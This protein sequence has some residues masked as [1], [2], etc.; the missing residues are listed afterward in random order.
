MPRVFLGYIGIFTQIISPAK[1]F[2]SAFYTVQRGTAASVRIEEIID[3]EETIAEPVN[4]K[5]LSAFNSEIRFN[6]VS[7]G[8][9]S[10]PV[11]QNI[12]LTIKKGQT[13]ALV[14][15]SGGGKSTLADLLP[16]FYD[17]TSG[18]ITIDGIDIRDLPL[19]ELRSLMGIVSQ[20]SIL[21]NDTLYNNIA[22]GKTGVS[23]AQ[24]TNAAQVANA[25]EFIV[26]TEK[27]YQTNIGDRGS[28]LSGGQRQ[29]VSI[30]R[31][32][33]K[34]PDILIL[35]EATSA[36]DTTSERLVQ[37]ALN[38]LMQNRTSVV[39]AHR[40][41]TIQNADTIVVL[42]QGKIIQTGTHQELIN[43]DGLYRRLNQMQQ[44]AE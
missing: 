30:A 9:N 23:A 27:G 25:D 35:D 2:S 33:L 3:A 16:R 5:H 14:G 42:E 28:K 21:F 11:L 15:P 38:N 19:H 26:N 4:P 41:S 1:A 6:N 18:S 43:Q 8:Y 12:N 13:V 39:I 29:R 7:F 40:L 17:V 32:V 34:N 37:E 22:F 31:A 44:L 10:E 24:I 36:L 20:E